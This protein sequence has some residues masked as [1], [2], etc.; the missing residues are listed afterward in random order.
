M[1]GKEFSAMRN[2]SEFTYC[3]MNPFR[4]TEAAGCSGGSPLIPLQWNQAAKRGAK[5]LSVP[6]QIAEFYFFGSADENS[7]SEMST[8]EVT[9]DQAGVVDAIL[10]WWDCYLL[11]ENLDPERSIKYSTAPGA[12]P[13]QDHWVQVIH[14]L[15]ESIVCRAGE[16]FMITLHTD[17][18]NMS[19]SAEVSAVGPP[20]E[21]LLKR[22]RVDDADSAE[23]ATSA[24]S[25]L[26]TSSTDDN[27]PEPSELCTCGWH[28]LCGESCTIFFL[29]RYCF[30]Y[31]LTLIL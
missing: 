2:I 16:K 26:E 8:A 3:G 23:A 5:M 4:S 31:I 10:V 25:H 13:W 30:N 28:M 24:G 20:D 19:I 12:Q 7:L 29:S 6:F 11:S 27:G 15:S 22:A 17:G 21:R 9:A 18:V 14:P 1:E